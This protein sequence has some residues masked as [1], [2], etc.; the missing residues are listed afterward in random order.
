MKKLLFLCLISINAQSQTALIDSV[1]H[2]LWNEKYSSITSLMD[3][4]LKSKL[5]ETKLKA[6]WESILKQEGS[7]TNVLK[8]EINQ[9]PIGKSASQ[10]VEFS[11]ATFDLKTSWNSKNQLSSLFIKPGLTVASDKDLGNSTVIKTTFTSSDNYVIKGEFWMPKGNGS[12]PLA[13]LVHGSGPNDRYSTLG[14]NTPFLDIA[15]QLSAKGIGVFIYDKRTFTYGLSDLPSCLTPVEE[16]ITDAVSALQFA[17]QQVNIDPSQI[18]IVGHSLGAMLMPRIASLTPDAKGYAMLSSPYGSL[19]ELM[20]Y[21]FEF[22]KKNDPK[23][24]PEMQYNWVMA[25]INRII[26]HEYTDSTNSSILLG[27]SPCY[28]KWLEKYNQVDEAKKIAKPLLLVSALNDYQVPKKEACLWKKK[29]KRHKNV[30]FVALK[31]LTHIYTE[32]ELSKG[33]KVYDGKKEVSL[34]LSNTLT[35]FILFH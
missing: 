26:K 29:L 22:I 18:F 12:Y 13:I 15:K 6:V 23:A 1:G 34:L 30:Q 27:V 24:I 10:T 2:W 21:Q 17:K 31:G 5:S 28:W 16:T 33:P 7:P 32:G 14:K 20:K 3:S 35:N 11:K 19:P 9:S 8:A 4:N 25:S